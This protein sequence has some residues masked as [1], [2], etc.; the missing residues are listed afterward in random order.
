VE[1]K[2]GPFELGGER[3]VAHQAHCRKTKKNLMDTRK[4][5]GSLQFSFDGKSVF[6][7]NNGLWGMCRGVNAKRTGSP[8][9]KLNVGFKKTGRLTPLIGSEGKM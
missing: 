6:E 8:L 9:R 3:K 1:G 5:Q 2:R 7:Q 4:N